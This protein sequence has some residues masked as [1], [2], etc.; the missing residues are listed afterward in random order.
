MFRPIKNILYHNHQ[1]KH[2]QILTKKYMKFNRGFDF[3][4]IILFSLVIP[5]LAAQR[6]VNYKK[7]I[8]LQVFII[9]VFIFV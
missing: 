9:Q 6:N 8:K 4:Q 1:G 7:N 3:L 5:D 2:F